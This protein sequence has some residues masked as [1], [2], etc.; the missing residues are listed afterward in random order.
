MTARDDILARIREAH[1]RGG[2]A[3]ADSE[4]AQVRGG[5]ACHTIGPRP[6]FARASDVRRQF[7]RECDRLGTTYKEA[8]AL[9]DV[10]AEVRRYLEANA[11]APRLVAWHELA[12]LDW[13]GAGIIVDDRPARDDDRIGLTG[14]FCAVA[15]SGSLVLLSGA[16]TP[17][18]TAL[19]P[20]T[21]I[22]IV[23]LARIVASLEDAFTLLRAEHGEPP[24]SMWFVSGP[25]RTAD[26]EQTIV[27]GAHGPYRA[28]VILVA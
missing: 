16:A 14:C 18:A 19:L 27:I 6:A 10:P 2:N 11:L 21:H 20:E 25:S 22:A 23:P 7:L 3:P 17:K 8:H 15:E 13:A 1:G 28:H 4:L 24:R 9:G 26:I 12:A 5:I